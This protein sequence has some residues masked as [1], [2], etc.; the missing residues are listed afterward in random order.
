[1]KNKP[2]M[3]A[4]VAA[5]CG[6]KKATVARVLDALAGV[7]AVELKGAEVALVPGIGRLKL[8]R[9]PERE[10]RRP[11]DGATITLPAKSFVKM[12]ITQSLKD[13]VQ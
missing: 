7:A 1:M 8:T 9:K 3:I 10:G 5:A 13:A 6:E 11:S 2:E 12:Q 4:A